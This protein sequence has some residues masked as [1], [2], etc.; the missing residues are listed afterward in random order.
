L[1]IAVAFPFLLPA[2]FG[3]FLVGFGVSSIVPMV[4]SAAGRSKVMTAGMALAAVS[5]IG[6]FGFLV[7]PPLIGILAGWSSLRLSFSIIALMGLAIALLASR[8]DLK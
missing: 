5:S 6:F 4:Y 1:F 7:G 2:L 8:A 3:F